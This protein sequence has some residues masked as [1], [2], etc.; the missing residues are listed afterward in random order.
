LTPNGRVSLAATCAKEI[1]LI[2]IA[3]ECSVGAAKV[4][5]HLLARLCVQRYAA[6]HN[7]RTLA[8][9]ISDAALFV[10]MRDV[11]NGIWLCAVLDPLPQ[12]QIKQS[13]G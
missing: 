11:V 3:E 4:R 12:A 9:S 6:H 7:R 2:A 13:Y 5:P 8:P 10:D 1:D